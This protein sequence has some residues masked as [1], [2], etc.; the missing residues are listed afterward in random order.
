MTKEQNKKNSPC[1]GYC[2]YD[3]EEDHCLGCFRTLEEI[4]RSMNYRYNIVVKEGK[5]KI[6]KDN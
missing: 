6:I 4:S 3:Y 1:T 2:V 5:P